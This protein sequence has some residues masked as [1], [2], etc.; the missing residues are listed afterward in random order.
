[1]LDES[2]PNGRALV[3]T[4]PRD[5]LRMGRWIRVID[6]IGF[7]AGLPK[8]MT[9]DLTDKLPP[10]SRI[11]RI[12]TSMRIYWDQIRVATGFGRA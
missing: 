7:P 1:M 11:V 8:T 9:V 2:D 5:P 4:G 10:D 3:N 6:A 12:G